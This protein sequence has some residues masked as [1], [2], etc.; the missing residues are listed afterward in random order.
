MRRHRFSVLAL[1]WLLLAATA[2]TAGMPSPLP[3]DPDKLI[4][5]VL[6]LDES[7]L[8]RLQTLSFFIVVLLLCALTVRWLWNSLQKE[9]TSLPRLSFGRAVA[10]VLLWGLLFVV[11]LTM[12][13][14]ARELMTPGAWRK[15]GFTYKLEDEKTDSAGSSPQA[16]RRQ[17][18]EQLRTALWQHAATHEGHFPSASEI[19]AIGDEL[20]LVPDA[21]GL[22]YLYIPGLSAGHAPLL[23]ACEP[24]LESERRLVLRIN[25]DIL[26]MRSDEIAEALKQGD[27]R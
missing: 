22:R 13:S 2:A 6:R 23:L 11:V 25:G 3:N 14:G 8:V 24:E 12:I 5:K 17:H 16:V 1:G 7:V 15:Q 20:W 18:L 26:S 27:K 4:R 21:G 10:G 19:T 9:F